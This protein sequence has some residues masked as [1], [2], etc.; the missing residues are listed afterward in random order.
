MRIG[1]WFAKVALYI[2]LFLGIGGVFAT[3][4]M[5]Q[6]DGSGLRSTLAFVVLGLVATP[7]SLGF[8]GLDALGVPLSGVTEPAVWQAGLGTTFGRTAVIAALSFGMSLLAMTASG[9]AARIFS[10]IAILGVGAALAASGY[11][12]AA[13]PQWLTR[14]MVFLHAAGTAFWAGALIPLGVVLKRGSPTSFEALRRFSAAIPFVVAI[15]AIAGIVLAI[16]QIE[17]PAA[18]IDTAY[19]NV[20]LVKLALLGVLFTLAVV[21]RWTLTAPTSRGDVSA[22]R[23][24]VRSIAAETVIIILIFAVAAA[25]RFTPPPRAGDRCREPASVHIHTAKAMADLKISPGRTGPVEAS[26]VIMSGDFGPLDA[27]EVTLVLSNPSAG[28]DF[29]R[30][31]ARKPGDGTW[32]VDGLVIPVSGRW[33]IRIDI[34][35][36]D[37][38]I[39]RLTGDVDIRP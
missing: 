20:L 17:T 9:T 32:R 15:L 28:I 23:H 5:T 6:N 18:F 4:W 21:N 39:T 1:A 3:A 11:A 31:P 27:K 13:E 7:L 2:G 36:S 8:Q 12:S 38:E 22:T 37:F 14:P 35:I 24:L 19:G 29:I 33:T 30:R 34:L 10:S 26:I 25:W 16:I